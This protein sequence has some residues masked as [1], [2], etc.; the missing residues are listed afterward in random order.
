MIILIHCKQKACVNLLYQSISAD[1]AHINQL[2]PIISYSINDQ[3]IYVALAWC[4][5][6]QRH[7]AKVI[8]GH[9]MTFGQPIL[10]IVHA[11]ELIHL[12]CLYRPSQM[13]T[14]HVHVQPC[15]DKG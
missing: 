11:A 7:V 3:A 13:S 6:N 4:A 14:V 2:A 15:R 10:F 9:S 8:A 5:Q 12:L 1:V